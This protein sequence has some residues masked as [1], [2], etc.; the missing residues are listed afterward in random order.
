MYLRPVR[1]TVD[2]VAASQPP[3]LLLPFRCSVPSSLSLLGLIKAARPY[4]PASSKKGE[5]NRPPHFCNMRSKK[6]KSK[7]AIADG[8]TPLFISMICLRSRD[9]CRYFVTGKSNSTRQS[10]RL[11]ILLCD[12][13]I[14]RAPYWA[15]EFI[16]RGDGSCSLYSS[17]HMM[18]FFFL[19]PPSPPPCFSITRR[20]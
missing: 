19:R 10:A 6:I 18:I 11:L 8:R 3:P 14:A 9:G 16:S 20:L 2:L 4:L 15:A 12:S 1:E 5:L 13:V 17:S 7:N